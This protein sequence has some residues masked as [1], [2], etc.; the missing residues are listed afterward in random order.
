MENELI[1][2]DITNRVNLIKLL[3][4]GFINGRNQNII[5]MIIPVLIHCV[6]NSQLFTEEQLNNLVNI[7]N[8]LNI[9]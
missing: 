4:F 3:D 7:I 2:I 9:N 8:S 1:L 6:E 5:N